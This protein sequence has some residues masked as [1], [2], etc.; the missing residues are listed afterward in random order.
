MYEYV[1]VYV[2]AYVFLC[3]S[4]CILFRDLESFLSKTKRDPKVSSVK[5]YVGK[6]W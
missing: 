4:T 1:F 2:Y 5:P 6:F 3:T